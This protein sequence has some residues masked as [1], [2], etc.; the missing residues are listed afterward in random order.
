MG[1]GYSIYD[2]RPLQTK[3]DLGWELCDEEHGIG[4]YPFGELS[5]VDISIN[6]ALLDIGSEGVLVDVL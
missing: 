1:E 5:A 4:G 6:C 2:T 3:D